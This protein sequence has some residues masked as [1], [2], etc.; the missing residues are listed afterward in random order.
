MKIKQRREEKNLK[1]PQQHTLDHKQLLDEVIQGGKKYGTHSE[2][3][4]AITKQLAV[5]IGSNNVPLS[6][7]ENEDFKKLVEVLGCR[8]EVPCRTKMGKELTCVMTRLRE[9]LCSFLSK[10]RRINLCTD[11][12]TKR[13]MSASFLGVTAHF[14]STKDHKRHNTTLAAR[15]FPSP[16]T[17]SCI[18]DLVHTILSEWNIPTYKIHR[19]LTDNGSNMVAA[20]KAQL[21]AEEREDETD[22]TDLDDD[23]TDEIDIDS[24][25][26]DS[27]NDKEDSRLIHQDL[28]NFEECEDEHNIAFFGF[29]RS[30]CF[31]HTL[32]LVVRI[33]DTCKGSKAVMKRVQ[34]LVAKV[35]KSTKATEKLISKAGK[36]LI[37]DCPTRWSSTYL[38][39]CRLLLVKVEL[40][41]VLEELQWDNLHYSHGKYCGVAE[42]VRNLHTTR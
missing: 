26:L 4:K 2:R 24:D 40:S 13:G 37:S 29:K 27:S 35:N 9:V 15:Q 32:Q 39:L 16:H 17:A 14:F 8:Y 25:P 21:V 5:H 34:K 31:S 20:I 30:S 36:K 10:A 3:H 19:I 28:E 33:F 11:I 12:W 7:V 22:N 42:A 23:H 41:S 18:A 1:L 6:V 38:M